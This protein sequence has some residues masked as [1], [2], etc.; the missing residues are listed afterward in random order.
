MHGHDRAPKKL[1]L[2]CQKL[3]QEDLMY[4]YYVKTTKGEANK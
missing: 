2:L 1:V 3:M 4:N